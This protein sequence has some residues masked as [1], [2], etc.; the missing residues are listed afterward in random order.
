[1]RDQTIVTYKSQNQEELTD[2]Q[3]QN[4]WYSD[5]LLSHGY[6]DPIQSPC[7]AVPFEAQLSTLGYVNILRIQAPNMPFT[8]LELQ[9]LQLP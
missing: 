1:M 8:N 2:C 9:Y 7:Q 3:Y 4:N 5:L 6:S